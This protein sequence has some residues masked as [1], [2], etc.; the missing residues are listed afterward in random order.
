[1][2][3]FR[4]IWA[5]VT[6]ASFVAASSGV[7]CGQSDDSFSPAPIFDPVAGRPTADRGHYETPV[8]PDSASDMIWEAGPFHYVPNYRVVSLEY[9]PL[10][11]RLSL[12][13]EEV[14]DDNATRENI[15]RRFGS[16]GASIPVDRIALQQV[17]AS[18]LRVI[19]R[20]GGD[21]DA[22]L[23]DGPVQGGPIEF[24]TRIPASNETLHQSL[25]A[26]LP[27]VF[28][29]EV[30]HSLKRVSVCEVRMALIQ[31]AVR[32][33]LTEIAGG[34][35]SDAERIAVAVSR[36]GLLRFQQLVLARLL[37][38]Q[39]VDCEE[40]FR[41][42]S[43]RVLEEF[44]QSMRGARPAE[45]LRSQLEEG[46]IWSVGVGARELGPA[47]V[48]LL[49]TALTTDDK[50][51]SAVESQVRLLRDFAS[52]STSTSEFFNKIK[53]DA[54]ASAGVD[55]FGIVGVDAGASTSFEYLKQWEKDRLD[56]FKRRLESD[57]AYSEQLVRESYMNFTGENFVGGNRPMSLNIDVL[58]ES[59]IASGLMA[60]FRIITPG[61][62][63]SRVER[64]AVSSQATASG[65]N[66]LPVGSVVAFYGDPEVLR[67]AGVWEVCDGG[68]IESEDS[69]L[70]G[71]NRP[72]LSDRFIM[73]V[74]VNGDS[75]DL[76]A[77]E[78][79]VGGLA[80]IPARPGGRSAGHTLTLNQ[81]PGHNHPHWH[82]LFTAR[83]GDF[84]SATT[85]RNGYI[86]T[87]GTNGADSKYHLRTQSAPP[88][89]AMSGPMQG[90]NVGGGQSHSHGLPGHP[91]EENRPPFVGLYY[92]IKIR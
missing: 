62:V 66:A 92:I 5:G 3:R 12:W 7:V 40:L 83:E 88:N 50:F 76:T 84:A 89:S 15:S 9:E 17:Q 24:S 60:D 45:E 38:E 87:Q 39:N 47:E 59:Q 61:E 13:F 25:V 14:G 29:L 57:E 41:E 53:G 21:P 78:L 4:C 56:E 68:R 11:R 16:T 82:Y 6:V 36:E 46:T 67:E 49:K 8:Y 81:I 72:D 55:V 27:L 58:Q 91:A 90:G 75:S 77:G 37:V 44:L 34:A 70:F 10:D 22:I 35:D 73:G 51:S 42:E 80:E 1:M 28:D 18:R 43:Q 63:F 20:V 31:Q 23:Y 64:Y 65:G 48:R 54:A 19:A 32:D 33:A 85:S 26:N 86:V 52:T 2:T 69:P 71:K 79:R 30:T 74:S